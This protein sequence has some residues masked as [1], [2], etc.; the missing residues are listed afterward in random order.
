MKQLIKF[1]LPAIQVLCLSLSQHSS[2]QP[3]QVWVNSNHFEP[4]TEIQTSTQKIFWRH[5]TKC[6]KN[7]L[8]LVF[9]G[10]IRPTQ[11]QGALNLVV[12]ISIQPIHKNKK[13]TI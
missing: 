5:N 10:K 3:K 8:R 13:Q 9:T 1:A 4:R 7:P 11:K 2:A 6:V 12:G